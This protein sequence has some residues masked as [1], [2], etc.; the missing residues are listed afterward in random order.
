MLSGSIN[1]CKWRNCTNPAY[2]H[3]TE[4]AGKQQEKGNRTTCWRLLFTF[5]LASEEDA[6]FISPERKWLVLHSHLGTK[7]TANT[8]TCS[9]WVG[10]VRVSELP[11][12]AP[13]M[14]QPLSCCQNRKPSSSQPQSGLGAAAD[15]RLGAAVIQ[16]AELLLPSQKKRSGTQTN[17]DWN[18]DAKGKA[19]S[20]LSNQVKMRER[21]KVWNEHTHKDTHGLW[22]QCWVSGSCC[23]FVSFLAKSTFSYFWLSPPACVC[24]CVCS[25]LDSSELYL[26]LFIRQQQ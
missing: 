23:V 11:L 2:L 7:H 5:L 17:A 25:L 26:S 20:I 1:I 10:D 19:F 18:S 24:V 9:H 12:T 3:T 22:V 8:C 21:H 16:Q 6:H 15:L 13:E 14:S 4:I